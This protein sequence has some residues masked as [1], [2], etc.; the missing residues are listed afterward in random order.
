M[1][2]RELPPSARAEDLRPPSKRIEAQSARVLGPTPRTRAHA[3]ARAWSEA[4]RAVTSN[5]GE[6]IKI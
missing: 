2:P 1:H 3:R 6:H 4:P 5:M